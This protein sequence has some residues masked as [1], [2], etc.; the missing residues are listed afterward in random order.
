MDA[1]EAADT[2]TDAEWSHVLAV[3]LTVPTRLIRAVL[4]M[5][6]AKKSGA[7]IN[8]A[9][10]A[11]LSGAAAGVAY[12]ASKHGLLGVTKNTAWRFHEDGIRCNAILP[13]GQCLSPFQLQ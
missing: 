3:N 12:T 11:A 13:G 4:P 7:I 2:C 10:K 1:F 9:S 6:K 5:M 8:V